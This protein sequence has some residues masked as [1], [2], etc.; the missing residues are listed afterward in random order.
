MGFTGYYIK[1]SKEK[2]LKMMMNQTEKVIVKL[3]I[4]LLRSQFETGKS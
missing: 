1:F 4:D 3:Q 2:T